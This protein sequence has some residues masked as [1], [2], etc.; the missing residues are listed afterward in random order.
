M[1]LPLALLLTGAALLQSA[2]PQSVSGVI[3]ES[4]CT[5]ANHSLMRMGDTDAE[6]AKACVDS[7]GATWLLFDGKQAW[8]LSDQ[9]TPA[10][11]AGKRVVV[12]GSVDPKAKKIAVQSIAPSK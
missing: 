6:C 4:E 3:T 11:F 7:H 9:K 8:A 5:D 2:S 1:K 10:E 12:T